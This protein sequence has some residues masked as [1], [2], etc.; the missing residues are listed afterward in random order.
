VT[1]TVCSF[2]VHRPK[3]YPDAVDYVPLL[4]AL[5]RSCKR[6][7]VLHVVLTDY[8]T[9]RK[10]RAA[11]LDCWSTR[12]PRNLMR[13]LTEAQAQWLERRHDRDT[14]TLFVGADCL[15]A[16]DPRHGLPAE[17]DLSLIYRPGHKR[18]RINNGF[19]YV[20]AASREKVARL[21][22]RIADG[23]GEAM[24]DDM[25]AVERALAPMPEGY[26]QHDR[27]GLR[28]NF[29]P[30]HLWNA[31]PKRLDEPPGEAFVLHFRGRQRKTIMADWAARWLT[32]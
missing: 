13:A 31:G 3:D 29:L 32:C 2:W 8:S 18:H 15:V 12:L 11:G 22:R 5:D 10:C 25:V 16:R 28:V 9:A 26:G 21:F 17:A 1:L 4:L 7:G 24:C 19:M 30:M 14:D 20:P 23:C 6:F 27:A